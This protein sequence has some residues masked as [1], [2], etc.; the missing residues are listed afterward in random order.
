MSSSEVQNEF[1]IVPTG[2]LNESSLKG[3]DEF[4][5]IGGD[6]DGQV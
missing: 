4:S 2:P 1:T 5:G 6:D 3:E